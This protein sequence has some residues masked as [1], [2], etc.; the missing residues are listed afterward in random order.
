ML[1]VAE[2]LLTPELI[3]ERYDWI[4]AQ[5]R[6]A[7]S[8]AG[9]DPGAFRVVAVTK[10]FDRSVVR[11]AWAAGLR[12]FGENRV[13]EAL[14][15]IEAQPH[16]E[17]HLVGRLQANKART[18]VRAFSIIHSVDSLELLARLD[19]IAAEEARAP[20]CLLEVNLTGDA[21]RAGFDAAWFAAEAGREGPLTATLRDVSA[22]RVAGLMGIAA[23]GTD[24][25]LA[26]ATFAHLRELRDRLA[27][28]LGRALPEL[29]MGMS[30][31]AKAAVAEG[32]TMVRIG[33]AIFG[34]RPG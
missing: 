33:T 24:P 21:S 30:A 28:R 29:S 15:K 5:L 4:V 13:Q 16:A 31:D 26:R 1:P 3:R 9:R 22:T 20:V 10:G 11:A 17:W 25:R 19:R 7:A 6:H 12:H 34:P 2:P 23:L 8:A 18:A 14:P 32:A 27:D